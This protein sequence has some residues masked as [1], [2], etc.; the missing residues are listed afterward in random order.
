MVLVINKARVD[1][2]VQMAKVVKLPRSDIST[3]ERI[4]HPFLSLL[5]PILYPFLME[6]WN[7]N[8]T[9]KKKKDANFTFE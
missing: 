7:V 2:R 8:A 1:K 3:R 5:S 4:G 9:K 6:N